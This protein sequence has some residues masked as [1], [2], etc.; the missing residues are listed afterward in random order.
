[1]AASKDV[2]SPPS[3]GPPPPA[4]MGGDKPNWF[5][6]HK[7][8]TVGIIIAVAVGVFLY[9][10]SKASSSVSSGG[11]STS[12]G[13]GSTPSVYEVSPPASG[14][15]SG[16]VGGGS[17]SNELASL[18]Q[19]LDTAINSNT[20]ALQNQSSVG[21][22]GPSGQTGS[23]GTGSTSGSSTPGSVGPSPYQPAS[24][25]PQSSLPSG[26]S[27]YAPA[28]AETG[29]GYFGSAQLNYLQQQVA[30]GKFSQPGYIA[31]VNAW[32]NLGGAESATAQ[33]MHFVETPTASGG[34]KVSTIPAVPTL[35]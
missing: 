18:I 24:N 31:A 17:S 29:I 23:T 27:T 26:S 19:A 10:R 34:I 6:E 22:G 21:S 25:S 28:P 4:D 8:A 20:A 32:N 35:R 30:A 2:I 1:M 11:T 5:K 16:G 12:A 13:S 7:G 14:G 9:A 33:S 3:E 15:L